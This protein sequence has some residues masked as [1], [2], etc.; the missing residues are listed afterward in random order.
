M[1][2]QSEIGLRIT[3]TPEQVQR[4]RKMV[5]PVNVGHFNEECLPPG[6]EIVIFF[7]GPFEHWA[8]AR[9]AKEEIDLGAVG[10]EPLQGGWTP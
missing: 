4:L 5:A 6:Y 3:L 8:V 2:N 10:I 7:A 1:D 9:C